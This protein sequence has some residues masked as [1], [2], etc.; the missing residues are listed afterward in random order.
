VGGR[1][2]SVWLTDDF[3][4][5][6]VAAGGTAE[7]FVLQRAEEPLDHAIGL[8]A[9]HPCPDVTAQQTVAGERVS[10]SHAMSVTDTIHLHTPARGLTAAPS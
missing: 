9:P 6:A 7:M 3:D 4:S 10:E 2:L 5:E 1:V 8:W